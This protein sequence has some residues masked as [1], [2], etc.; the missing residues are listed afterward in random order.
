[1][2]L[3]TVVQA[4]TKSD[5]V[6]EVPLRPTKCV[7]ARTKSDSVREVP[8]R[9][10]KSDSVREVPLRPTKCV[11]VAEIHQRNVLLICVTCNCR[12]G[13]GI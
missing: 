13:A 8:L 11:F 7:Q 9:P 1:M 5:S 6:R 4:R 3:N 2:A 12:L 10:T